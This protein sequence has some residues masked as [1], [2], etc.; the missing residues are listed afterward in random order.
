[1]LF[2]HSTDVAVPEVPLMD[3]REEE[4]RKKWKSCKPTE[5]VK[6]FFETHKAALA[7]FPYIRDKRI[8]KYD[9]DCGLRVHFSKTKISFYSHGNSHGGNKKLGEYPEMT[10]EMAKVAGKS[11]RKCAVSGVTVQVAIA[12]YENDLRKR[13]QF[14]SFSESS[15]PTYRCRTQKLAKYFD[16]KILFAQV[17]PA[18]VQ[19]ALDEI[20]ANE[21]AN[22]AG[23]LF[24][25]LKRVWKFCSPLYAM[26]RNV[27]DTI[28][29]NYVSS[30]CEKKNKG[31]RIFPEPKAVAELYINTRMMNSQQ[32]RNAVR[33]LI[34]SGVRPKNVVNLKWSC[35]DNPENPTKI[36]YF[37]SA[38][39]QKRKFILP[40]TPTL[41]EVIK[42]QWEFR[43][44]AVMEINQ[45]FVFLKPTELTK[46][47]PQRSLD[48]LIKNYYPVDSMIFVEEPNV[49]GKNSP[50]CTLF[51]K[52]AKSNIAGLLEKAGKSAADGRLFS[53]VALGHS[54]GKEFDY[55]NLDYNYLYDGTHETM[56]SGHLLGLTLHES[57]ILGNVEKQKDQ[58]RWSIPLHAKKAALA[59]ENAARQQMR[60]EIK[61]RYGKKEY[62]EFLQR[63]VDDIGTSVKK[64]LL[65][66]EGR[67]KVNALLMA[68]ASTQ[69]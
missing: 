18:D 2:N 29:K 69:S 61:N 43:K 68:L 59:K 45:E 46:P 48:K 42:E 63:E 31:T 51:R 54:V 14:G 3:P 32:Q 35:V 47:F 39:K 37:V 55:N 44:N 13:V 60:Q 23:E 16:T 52:F 53:A 9:R 66:P 24:K 26:G 27:V 22:Y 62:A 57:S 4:V 65:C 38:M 12:S 30:R 28:P 20:I 41:I 21:S 50:F 34:L 11:L 67:K 36:T 7:M 49:K 40:L 6:A 64:A 56:Y 5:S 19:F 25:E 17:T 10:L 58:P 8:S 33:F 1:M 15:I